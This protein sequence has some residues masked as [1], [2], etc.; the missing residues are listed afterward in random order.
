MNAV[1]AAAKARRNP[2]KNKQ[3]HHNAMSNF[4][5]TDLLQGSLKGNAVT[6]MITCISQSARNGDETYLSL[7]YSAGMAELLK[8]SRSHRQHSLSRSC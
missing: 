4:C 2:Q 1:V 8:M 5:L 7:K 6:A 3:K